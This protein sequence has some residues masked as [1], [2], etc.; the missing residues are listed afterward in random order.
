[1][2]NK[3]DSRSKDDLPPLHQAIMKS[4][5]SE[6]SRLLTE[7]TD[8]EAKKRPRKDSVTSSSLAGA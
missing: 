1:M 6:N 5:R 2:S 3:V 7:N 4:D 8:I